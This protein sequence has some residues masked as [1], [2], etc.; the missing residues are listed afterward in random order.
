MDRVSSHTFLIAQYF[1]HNLSRLRHGNGA[2]LAEIYSHDGFR[3]RRTQ[4]AIVNFSLKTADGRCVGFAQ[5]SA[6]SSLERELRWCLDCRKIFRMV[7][8][9][10]VV[11]V[12]MIVVA[13][14]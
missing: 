6:A 14:G 12:V 11:V 10:V 8:V 3:D 1:A 9:L 7:G 4:G 5:V 13:M 2:A